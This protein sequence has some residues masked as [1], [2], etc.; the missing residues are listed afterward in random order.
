MAAGLHDERSG[1]GPDV[2]LVHGALGDYRQ[3]DAIASA[4]SPRFR[5]HA[6]SRRHHWPGP[7]PA[8]DAPYSYEGHR[9]DLV[10]FLSAIGQPVHLV[11]HSYGAGVVLMA[12][13]HS[14]EQLRSLTIIEPAFGSLLPDVVAGLDEERADRAAGL[15]QVRALADAG[16]DAAAA[17]SFTDW[18][19]GGPGGFAK[20]PDHVQAALIQNARTLLPMMA[21]PQP[22]VAPVHLRTLG[23]RTLVVNGE[24]S[25]LWY[26]L[27]G[28]AAASL[29]PG[30]CAE[31]LPGCAHMT[32]VEDPARMAAVLER[33]LDS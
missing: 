18:I 31:T 8:T 22:D 14:P 21:A 30:A 4:L 12:A 24:Y 19:Q 5:V 7:M 1:S 10:A 32:I 9:D 27:I 15:A 33:F 28:A 25:R 17:E 20:L 3:W 6:V 26:R 29:I 11:G 2:V 16:Q 13:L 23:V